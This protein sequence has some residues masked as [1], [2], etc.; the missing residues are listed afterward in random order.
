MTS[1]VSLYRVAV[2]QVNM[3]LTGIPVPKLY[4]CVVADGL[5]DSQVSVN[6]QH[7]VSDDDSVLMIQY[8]TIG[9]FPIRRSYCSRYLL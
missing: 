2:Y 1:C 9:Q 8:L 6:R 7:R 3:M 4:L 5:K